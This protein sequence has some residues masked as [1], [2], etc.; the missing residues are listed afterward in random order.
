MRQIGKLPDEAEAHRLADYL[1]TLDIPSKV[2]LESDGWSLWVVHEDQRDSATA[3]LKDFVANPTD[4]KY[5]GARSRAESIRREQERADRLHRKNT[6]NLNGTLGTRSATARSRPVT[7][8]LLGL[9]LLVAGLTTI[10]ST[11]APLQEAL[12]FADPIMTP[13]GSIWSFNGLRHGQIWRLITPIFL[14]FGPMHLF[15]N[16]MNLWQIGGLIEARRSSTK[17]LIL[18]VVSAV[19]S[20][21]GQVALG[22]AHMFGGMSGVLCA[23]FGYV[24]ITG[25]NDPS[26]GMM[27]TQNTVLFFLVFLALCA[28]GAL[29]PIANGAHFAGL[30]VGI[31]FAALRF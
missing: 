21:L 2:L 14:H 16:M 13:T 29:G 11:N 5:G 1:L 30:A 31:V 4:S 22:G 26:S 19:L 28:T 27:L 9:S 25:R 15:F 20:N 7:T 12:S 6:K 18:A 23:L 24:W 17:M 3:I 10:G 8:V